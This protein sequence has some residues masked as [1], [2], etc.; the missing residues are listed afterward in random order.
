[1]RQHVIRT[2]YR[3]HSFNCNVP[4]I[5]HVPWQPN[6]KSYTSSC[7]H[8]GMC[9]DGFLIYYTHTSLQVYIPSQRTSDRIQRILRNVFKWNCT[10]FPKH[11]LN[12]D[13]CFIFL[14]MFIFQAN[15]PRHLRRINV[16]LL[17]SGAYS[18]TPWYCCSWCEFCAIVVDIIVQIKRPNSMMV[19]GGC[20][21][22][23]CTD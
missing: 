20:F 19:N 9:F 21:A 15:L 12:V 4:I 6:K 1:M 16:S 17:D 3:N 11:Q 23:T 10:F 22:G 13:I 5:C 7:V 2:T 8:L 18:Q 14:G